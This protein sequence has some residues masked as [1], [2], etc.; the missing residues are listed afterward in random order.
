MVF[1]RTFIRRNFTMTSY[2]HL[3]IVERELIFLYSRMSYS[4]RRIAKLLKR[5]P[6]TISRELRRHS[7][8]SFDYTPS[9]AQRRYG[10]N[11]RCCGRSRLLDDPSLKLIVESLFIGH[12]WSPEQISKRLKLERPKQ[13]ISTNTIYRAIYRGDFNYCVSPNSRGALTRLRRRGKKYGQK[14][15]E[16]GRGF[17]STAKSIHDRPEE[18]EKRESVGHWEAD[19]VLGK[20]GKSCVVTLVDRKSRYLLIGKSD[21]KTAESV[22]RTIQRLFSTVSSQNKK[23]ITPDRGLEFAYFTR[24]EQENNIECFFADPSS[25]WQRG[26][27]EN[28]NGLVREYLRKRTDI[29]PV[30][31]ELIQSVADK[32][33][34]RPRK[35]LDWKT[36][37]EVFYDKVLHLI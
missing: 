31:H 15:Y 32:I 34:F 7:S 16:D 2:K 37:F 13:A 3:T 28:T 19:T 27:N 20:R 4:I 29:D 9:H 36:P 12:Q 26:T 33:N 24:I 21:S 18:I 10:K 30:P 5:S 1:A 22:T 23:T 14:K 25:P 17:F 11:K 8:E 35:C 6:S